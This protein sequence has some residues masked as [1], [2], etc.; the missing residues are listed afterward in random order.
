MKAWLFVK[1]WGLWIL[2]LLGLIAGAF[3]VRPNTRKNNTGITNLQKAEEEIRQKEID[4]Q[5]EDAQSVV[6]EIKDLNETRKPDIVPDKDKSMEDLAK[7]Y[8]KL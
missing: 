4:K 7:E 2:G 3:L 6:S 8:D 5:K 1:K